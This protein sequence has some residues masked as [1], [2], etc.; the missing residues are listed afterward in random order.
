[1]IAR[2][3]LTALTNALIALT[4]AL[5]RA[6]QEDVVLLNRAAW[7]VRIDSTLDDVDVRPAHAAVEERDEVAVTRPDGLWEWEVRRD[8]V[9]SLRTRKDSRDD[10]RKLAATLAGPRTKRRFEVALGQVRERTLIRAFALYR[11]QRVRAWAA[12]VLRAVLAGYVIPSGV[13]ATPARKI[14]RARRKPRPK[15]RR[16]GRKRRSKYVSYV[17]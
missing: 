4:N 6:E 17:A 11:R 3:A 8:F 1:M 2:A 16:P 5:A 10:A 7:S 9:R 13:V 15:S 14:T 12:R